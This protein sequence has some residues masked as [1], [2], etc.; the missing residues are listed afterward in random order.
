M[1]IEEVAARTPEK[2]LNV[3]LD[4]LVG[5]CEFQARDLAADLRLE[6]GQVG[7][8]VTTVKALVKMFIECDCS[9]V[10]INPLVVAGDA[11]VPLDC[12]LNVDDGALRSH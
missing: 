10:E 6:G 8:F 3:Q 1:A 12:K 11:I 9:L 7:A 2:I 4:P 5:L